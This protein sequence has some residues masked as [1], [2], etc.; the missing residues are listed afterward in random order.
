MD[1]ANGFLSQAAACV[2]A[3][4]AAGDWRTRTLH[5]EECALW[6]SLARNS[7]A[8]AALVRALEQRDDLRAD[9]PPPPRPQPAPPR[10]DLGR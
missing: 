8:T 6:I 3:A 10:M 9:P 4:E 7:E 2:R 5:L 1:I